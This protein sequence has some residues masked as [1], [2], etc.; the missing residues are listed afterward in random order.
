M[1]FLTFSIVLNSLQCNVCLCLFNLLFFLLLGIMCMDRLDEIVKL[2]SSNAVGNKEGRLVVQKYIGKVDT[3]KYANMQQECRSWQN[4]RTAHSSLCRCPWWSPS[5]F[6]ELASLGCLRILYCVKI[7]IPLQQKGFLTLNL[8]PPQCSRKFSFKSFRFLRP[9]SPGGRGLSYKMVLWICI[10]LWL[11]H[12]LL[13]PLSVSS[14]KRSTAGA[15]VVPYR[16]W[17][18]NNMTADNVL[19]KT[20]YL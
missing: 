19:C 11:K 2:V 18:K 7:S 3:W 6:K 9:T 4:F 8:S 10:F 13:V 12:T 1:L 14:L 15:F 17:D 20:C 16:E 5:I